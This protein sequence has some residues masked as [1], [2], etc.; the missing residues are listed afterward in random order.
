MR[1]FIGIFILIVSLFGYEINHENWA[2]F[3]K[4]IGEANG[5]KFEVYMNYFK[6]EFENFKQSKSFKV[7]A[8]ISGHIFFDGTKYDYEKGNLEQNSS[9]IS[10]LNA[11][12]DKIN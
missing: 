4:F 10:S 6:D 8:K 12:S 2:K 11:V 3:Y 7:P 9:E 1:A 5:I